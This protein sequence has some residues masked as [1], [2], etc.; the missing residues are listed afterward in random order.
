M[1]EDRKHAIRL[2]MS[3]PYGVGPAWS[4]KITQ[5]LLEALEKSEAEKLELEKS[6]AE[7]LELEN[8]SKE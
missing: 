1:D 6:E 8:K 3:H 7:K 4:W 2:L 5:E